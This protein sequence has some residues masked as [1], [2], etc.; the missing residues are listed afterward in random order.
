MEA[1]STEELLRCIEEANQRLKEVDPERVMVGS[2][3]VTAL[4]PSL[5]QKESARMAK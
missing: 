3:D 4:Y 1:Q 5:D 2:M